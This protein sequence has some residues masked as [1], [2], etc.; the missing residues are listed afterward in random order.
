MK[1][2]LTLNNLSDQFSL[3][4]T[5]HKPVKEQVRPH[6][7]LLNTV[8]WIMLFTVQQIFIHQILQLVSLTLTHWIG[9][10]SSGQHYPFSAFEQL[11]RGISWIFWHIP[12]TMFMQVLTKS[13]KLE[14]STTLN[15]DL[16]SGQVDKLTNCMSPRGSIFISL[17]P[18]LQDL[19]GGVPLS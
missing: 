19:P 4:I 2:K 16:R 17:L 10:L 8:G 9:D 14:I 15:L 1:L 12:S 11:G 6:M 13:R 18:T 5:L 3:Q 7:Q